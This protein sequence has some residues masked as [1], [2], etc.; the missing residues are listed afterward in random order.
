MIIAEIAYEERPPRDRRTFPMK[1]WP[2][3]MSQLLARTPPVS[4][5]WIVLGLSFLLVAYAWR[6][7]NQDLNDA[8]Q[9][10]FDYRTVE[11]SSAVIKRMLNYEQVLRGGRGLFAASERV[12]RAEWHAYVS[13]QL[14]QVRY[15]GIQGIGF[16]IHIASDD[17]AAHERSIR[18]EGFQDYTIH[19]PGIRDEY[20]PIIYLEPFDWRNKRAFGY[21]MFSEPTRRTAMEQARDTGETVISGKVTL[22]QEA[23]T[24]KQAGMLMYLPVYKNGAPLETIEMR[25]VALTGYVY[26]PFRM[27]DLMRGILQKNNNEESDL[28]IEVFDGNDTNVDA[29]LY[30]DDRMLR[31]GYDTTSRHVK[32]VTVDLHG[33]LWTLYFTARPGFYSAFDQS[34]PFYVLTTGIGVSLL[35]FGLIWVLATQRR[36]AL[37]LADVMSARARANA[38][39]ISAILNNIVDGIIT[40]NEIGI[41]ESANPAVAKIFECQLNEI[42]G[43]NVKVLMPRSYQIQHDGYLQH[44]RD[45]GEQ[46]IIGAGREVEGQRTDGTIFPLELSV[47]ELKIEGERLFIGVVRDLSERNKEEQM[48]REFVSTVSHELRTPLTAIHGSLGLIVGGVSGS[49][50]TKAKEL[51]DV[52]HRNCERLVRLVNDILDIEKIDSGKMQMALAA[53]RI[54]PLV[55]QSLEANSGYASQHQVTMNLTSEC[56]DATAMVDP[57]RLAQVMA[58]LLSNAIKFSP[59]Q[60]QVDIKVEQSEHQVRVE[61]RDY[62]P[63]IPEDFRKR[64]FMRFAQADS[65][66]T[67]QKGGTGLGLSISRAIIQRLGGKIGYESVAG[68][69]TT[70]YFS[71]TRLG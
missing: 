45:T 64:I 50:P 52:A 43:Q 20:T 30:D 34:K 38:E 27:N 28:D 22:V 70:F 59:P 14:I 10:Q 56:D 39:R 5:A 63:G 25:R 1:H 23:G 16:A 19:P 65:S 12:S 7:A 48:K 49:L 15:P 11:I 62:G 9:K 40:I 8:E 37:L 58:N 44:H 36:R 29:L 31:A 32:T 42:I 54:L 24:E 46:R 66:D 47:S 71:L 35:L 53:T 4:T 3:V 67:R 13:S 2:R 51:I 41:I 57:D 26:S 17:K 21:D 6:N 18:E 55:Q 60:G 69:G 68:E 33:R 61:V